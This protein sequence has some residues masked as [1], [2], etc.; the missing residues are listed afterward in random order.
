MAGKAS[1]VLE[2]LPEGVSPA[3]VLR[4]N[5]YE[6]KLAEKVRLEG[7]IQQL[8]TSNE[9]IEKEL[10]ESTQLIGDKL[11][12]IE[13]QRKKMQLTVSA[14][15]PLYEHVVRALTHTPLRLTCAVMSLAETK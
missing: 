5:A 9:S 14:R 2:C 12:I 10:K 15:I 6:L 1:P 8:A 13:E 3:D 4:M 7:E 11:K